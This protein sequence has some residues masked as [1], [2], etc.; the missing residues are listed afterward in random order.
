MG[1][2]TH[3]ISWQTVLACLGSAT[4]CKVESY[5][6]VRIEAGR[7]HKASGYTLHDLNCSL[8]EKS[9]TLSIN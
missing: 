6:M 9:K 8:V 4:H 7:Q 3:G 2:P 5:H 1:H